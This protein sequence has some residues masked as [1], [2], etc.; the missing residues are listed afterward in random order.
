MTAR[1]RKRMTVHNASKGR[2]DW[3]RTTIMVDPDL[4]RWA[5]QNKVK[6]VEVLNNALQQLHD[7]DA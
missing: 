3:E 5:K 1:T 4:K 6:L 2:E 7:A